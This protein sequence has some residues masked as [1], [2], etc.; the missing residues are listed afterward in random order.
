MDPYK[1]MTDSTD[2]L[3]GIRD[4]QLSSDGIALATVL[5]GAAELEDTGY[6]CHR[7]SAKSQLRAP[8]RGLGLQAE[9]LPKF[10]AQRASR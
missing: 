9:R 10:D 3:R 6:E 4:A 2:L 5:R 8:G 7:G 1:P